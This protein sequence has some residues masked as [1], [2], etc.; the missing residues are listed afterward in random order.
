MV[1]LQT[2]E[3]EMAEVGEEPLGQRGDVVVVEVQLGDAVLE[4]GEGVRLYRCYA[5]ALLDNNASRYCVRISSSAIINV[6]SAFE[7]GDHYNDGLESL[8]FESKQFIT[9]MITSQKTSKFVPNC[10]LFR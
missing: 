7:I 6:C 3:G 1:V 8:V 5:D 10:C 4:A 9:D 2:E